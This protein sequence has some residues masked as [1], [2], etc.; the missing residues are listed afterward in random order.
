MKAE[1]IVIQRPKHQC[2]MQRLLFAAITLL[3]WMAW[4]AL[5]LPLITL[6][7][8][9][10]GLRIGYAE[11]LLREHSQGSHDLQTMLTIFAM[12]ALMVAV[13]SSYNYL[14]YGRLKR[15]HR[16]AL[17][18]GGAIARALGVQHPTAMYMRVA[19]RVVLEFLDD[20]VA[21][22]EAMYEE[23]A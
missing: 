3:A 16:S 9:T 17:V 20:G 19:T 1:A 6:L 14:R 7:A 12:C 4:T 8:W 22:H 2:P 13:W 15:Q 18:D 11:L 5:W 23:V 21:M 10:L